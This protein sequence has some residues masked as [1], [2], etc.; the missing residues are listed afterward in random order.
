M[1]MPGCVVHCAPLRL[2][3]LVADLRHRGARLSTPDQ[4][5]SSQLSPIPT[6]TLSGTLSFA[7]CA[8]CD[9]S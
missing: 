2:P 8:M 4:W 7:A 6:S 9:L 5:A 1:S 3:V